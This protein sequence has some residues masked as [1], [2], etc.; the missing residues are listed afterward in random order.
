MLQ[1]PWPPIG[2]PTNFSMTTEWQ[3]ENEQAGDRWLRWAAKPL[4]E[5]PLGHR[6]QRS[7]PN[8]YLKCFVPLQNA[9]AARFNGAGRRFCEWFTI[10]LCEVSPPPLKGCGASGDLGRKGERIG[11]CC[12]ER[13]KG[14][15]GKLWWDTWGGRWCLKGEDWSGVV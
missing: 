7:L 11:V 2:D 9:A 4:S 10:K 5:M 14:H 1:F 8:L 12:E 13:R 3:A 6:Q 15:S